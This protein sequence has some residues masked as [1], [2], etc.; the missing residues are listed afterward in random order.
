METLTFDSDDLD[1]T[2]DFL[3]RAYA[4]M[5]IGSGTPGSNRARIRRAGI[6]SVSVDSRWT[7]R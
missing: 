3:S 1:V 7:S 2:E 6:S 5:C 4:R